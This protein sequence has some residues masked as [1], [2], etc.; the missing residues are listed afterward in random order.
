MHFY[1]I[2]LLLDLLDEYGVTQAA[3]IKHAK[4]GKM[5]VKEPLNLGAEQLDPLFASALHLTGDAQLG[6]KLGARI[7]MVPQGILG[8]A[9]V[10]SPT[11]GDALKLLVRYHRALLPSVNIKLKHRDIELVLVVEGPP[12][13]PQLS[14]FYCEVIYVGVLTAGNILLGQKQVP[15]SSVLEL[16]LDYSKPLN[17]STYERI[18]GNRVKFNQRYNGLHFNKQSLNTNISTSNPAAQAVFARECERLLPHD[19]TSSKISEQVKVQLISARLEFPSCQQV[20]R[21]LHMSEST[22]RRRLQKEGVGFQELLDQVRSKL[23][24]EY[25]TTTQLPVSEIAELLGFSDSANFRR[26]FKRWTKKTP[27]QIRKENRVS[28]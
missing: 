3:L 13:F 15:T 26:A 24:N 19:K 7:N 5:V 18:F 17:T 4:V 20:A 12:L 16:F 14:R 1:Y 6:L 2:S 25:L 9:L 21:K 11:I 28:N 10:T 22:L 27:S 8:Y 23:A